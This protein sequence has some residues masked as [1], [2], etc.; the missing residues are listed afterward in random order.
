MAEERFGAEWIY[1]K[2]RNKSQPNINV[3]AA[4]KA[5]GH[6]SHFDQPFDCSFGGWGSC[7]DSC[8][9]ETISL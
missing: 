3:K 6:A 5:L 7:R 4:L 1:K 2:D 8:L 9:V